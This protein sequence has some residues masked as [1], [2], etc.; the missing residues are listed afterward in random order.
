MDTPGTFVE[1]AARKQP[2]RMETAATAVIVV[3]MQN[4]FAS[5]GGM[6]DLA[7]I[8]ITGV[9]AIVPNVQAVLSAARLCRI[10]DRLP[11][12]GIQPRSDRCWISQFADVAEART[13]AGR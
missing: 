6:F 9:R 2:F 4:D 11:Q 12:D 13:A 8:D 3:D 10:D 5:P 1:V 7:G